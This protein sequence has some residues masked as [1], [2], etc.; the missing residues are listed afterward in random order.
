MSTSHHASSAYRA[1]VSALAFATVAGGPRGAAAQVPLEVALFVSGGVYH[2]AGRLPA[3]PILTS[4]ENIVS[5]GELGSAPVAG[6]GVEIRPVGSRVSLRVSG[7]RS[8]YRG[9]TGQW[10]C[11]AN[12]DGSPVAC[13]DILGIF[14]AEMAMTAAVADVVIDVSLDGVELR[15]LLGVAWIR[16]SYR[17][18]QRFVGSFSLAPNAFDVSA[19]ALHAG[20]GLSVPIRTIR[21]QADYAELHTASSASRPSRTGSATLGIFVPVR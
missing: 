15:P 6:A 1:L 13:P 12:P 11:A 18:D 3:A 20:I 10:G 9:E 5:F 21:V 16:H 8:L 7:Q 19:A 17:W 2:A 4:D 14:E